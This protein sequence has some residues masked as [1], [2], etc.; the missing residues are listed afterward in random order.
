MTDDHGS[1][2]RWQW[3]RRSVLATALAGAGAAAVGALNPLGGAAPAEAGSVPECFAPAGFQYRGLVCSPSS[4]VTNCS[5]G[6]CYREGMASSVDNCISKSYNERHRTCGED[7][8]LNGVTMGFALR[9]NA[10]GSNYY[11]GWEWRNT[12]NGD[13]CGCGNR[14]PQWACNDGYLRTY[15]EATQTWGAYERSICMT[16]KC[17]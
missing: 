4:Y 15:D 2:D 8:V 9:L 5:K 12:D 17:V 10:C 7:R 16:F 3:T 11:H 13:R 14:R 1:W 6:G